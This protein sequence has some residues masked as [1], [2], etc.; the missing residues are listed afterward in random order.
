VRNRGEHRAAGYRLTENRHVR[1]G[2]DEYLDCCG[3][4]TIPATR[5]AD[6][7]DEIA[8]GLYP[9]ILSIEALAAVSGI[10]PTN[11]GR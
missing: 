10:P 4:G 1:P 5:T 7:K 2:I 6:H 9:T 3:P 11:I 8:N